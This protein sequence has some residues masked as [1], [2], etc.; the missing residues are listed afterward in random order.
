MKTARATLVVSVL[1]GVLLGLVV[2]CARDRA[3]RPVVAF[4]VASAQVE[5]VAQAVALRSHLLARGA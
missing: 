2:K 1:A 4:S 5:A 3:P